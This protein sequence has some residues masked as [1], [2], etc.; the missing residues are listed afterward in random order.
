MLQCAVPPRRLRTP[1][2]GRG[3]GEGQLC[4]EPLG[5]IVANHCASAVRRNCCVW[6]QARRRC[7]DCYSSP[8]TGAAPEVD[9][10]RQQLDNTSA[11]PGGSAGV[12]GLFASLRVRAP[13]APAANRRIFVT[14][15]L[16]A[17]LVCLWRRTIWSAM[18]CQEEPRA[19]AR[20][21][22]DCGLVCS[23]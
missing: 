6:V 4:A 23:S 8:R 13:S 14:T 18:S 16:D 21:C 1:S 12:P 5:R 2:D 3:V 20:L 7:S 17:E 11:A 19:L 15:F 10:N 9:S 22:G